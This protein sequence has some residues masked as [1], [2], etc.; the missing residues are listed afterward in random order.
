M[1]TYSGF[2]EIQHDLK[3]G[4]L[5]CVERVN[6]HLSLIQK[7]KHLNAFLSVYGDEALIRAEQVDQ[8]IKNGTAG[9][10]A[11]LIVGL[12]DVLCYKDHPLQASSKILN[13]FVSQFNG[14]AVQRLLDEDAIIIG[15]Q[16]CDEF[17]MGSSNE[18]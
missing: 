6:F 9:K 10:L 11:G 2:R 14:T 18:T 13:G 5:S 16:N 7:K 8:K 17:A 15:R 12:K 3:N 4:T 1:K